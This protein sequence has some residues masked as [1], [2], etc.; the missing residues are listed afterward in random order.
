MVNL[1][2]LFSGKKVAPLV[3]EIIKGNLFDSCFVASG[4]LAWPNGFELCA[5]T[6]KNVF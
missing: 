3:A 1:S 6:G 4:H 5:D 2:Y